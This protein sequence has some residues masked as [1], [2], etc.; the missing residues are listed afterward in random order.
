MIWLISVP[1]PVGVGLVPTLGLSGQLE[2]IYPQV[3][4]PANG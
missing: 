4:L 2:W 3:H 1:F